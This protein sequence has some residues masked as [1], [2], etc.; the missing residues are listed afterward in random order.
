MNNHIEQ[1]KLNQHIYQKHQIDKLGVSHESSESWENAIY[2]FLENWFDNSDVI[3]TQTSG[4]TGKPKEIRLSKDAMRNSARMTN[5]FFGLDNSKTA[6]LCLPASYIAGKMMMVR[7]IVGGFNLITTEPKAN[8]FEDLEIQV[9]FTAITPYQL[10]YS[11][12]TLKNKFVKNI[13]VGGGHVNGKLEKLAET[14][15]ARLFET[16]GMTETCSHIALRQ[17]NGSGKSDV[18]TVLESVKIST[19]ERNCLVI[20]APHLVHNKLITNDIVQIYTPNTFSWL[21]RADSVINSGGV[22][23]FPEQIEKKL[24]Q[25]I[26]F[27]YFVTSEPDELL[28]ERVILIVETDVDIN[29]ALNQLQT[30][31]AKYEIPKAIYCIPKFEYSTSNKVLRAETIAAIKGTKP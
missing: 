11:A 4:S 21:G 20:D 27:P 10:Y 25:L 18:F 2:H 16:Y 28:G 9:D 8:P 12:E 14:I 26:P 24:E 13:I 7:A 1:I 30:M 31:L 6:L 3:V 29:L 22:K 19:D 17:F 15:S 5:A 23:I